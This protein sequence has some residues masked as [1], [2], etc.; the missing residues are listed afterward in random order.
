MEGAETTDEPPGAS[1]R[2]A[3]CTRHHAVHTLGLQE[4]QRFGGA[5]PNTRPPTGWKKK[6]KKKQCSVRTC[7]IGK[8]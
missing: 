1:C 7:F 2:A 6:E 4:L 8:K 3:V 5:R